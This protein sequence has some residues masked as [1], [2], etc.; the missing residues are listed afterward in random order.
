MQCH[1]GLASKVQVD[2]T[3]NE[4][5]AAA[6][7]DMV[8]SELSF[9]NVHYF[10]AGA[11]LYGNQALGGYQYD[12]KMY[13]GKFRHTAGIDTCLGC[14]DQH[15]LTVKVEVCA[16]CHAGVSKVEDLQNVRMQGS[17]ADYDGDGNTTEGIAAEL[18]GLQA[19]LLQGIQA[20]GS[21]VAGTSIGYTSDAYPYF[22]IDTNG[23]GEIG[24]DEAAFDNAYK[25]WT[26]RLLKPPIT[27]RW[28][29]KIR[30]SLHITPST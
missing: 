2:E 18:D 5:G 1:Q 7:P 8:N 29:L 24:A 20:Y 9:I 27:T 16:E 11:T 12:D 19:M 30:A 22:F 26:A 14:H 23:D 6:D 25:S 13:D 15:T 10:P 21:E 4:L 28:Q 17:L 3:I